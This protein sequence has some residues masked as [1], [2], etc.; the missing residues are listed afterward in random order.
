MRVA[1]QAEATGAKAGSLAWPLRQWPELETQL[2]SQCQRQT[3]QGPVEEKR[4]KGSTTRASWAS[5]VIRQRERGG[6]RKV[7]GV[8]DVEAKQRARF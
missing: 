6:V 2:W 7:V 8:C 1:P 3:H 4:P 5:T